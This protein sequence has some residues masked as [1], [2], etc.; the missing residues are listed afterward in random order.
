MCKEALQAK[1]GIRDGVPW[2]VEAP[3]KQ[4][5]HNVGKRYSLI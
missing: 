5:A 1:I 4:K 2:F 3:L